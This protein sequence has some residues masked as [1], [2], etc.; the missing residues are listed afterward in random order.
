MCLGGGGV[1]LGQMATAR[2][3][4][5]DV[6]RGGCVRWRHGTCQVPTDRHIRVC[7]KH[8]ISV[9]EVRKICHAATYYYYKHTYPVS[10]LDGRSRKVANVSGG[11]GSGSLLVSSSPHHRRRR[12]LLHLPSQPHCPWRS[13][14]GRRSVAD[15]CRFHCCCCCCRCSH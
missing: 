3:E 8:W 4:M 15:C 13:A 1:V 10:A 11:S 5:P 2:T 6:H 12:H 7:V 14:A 9:W